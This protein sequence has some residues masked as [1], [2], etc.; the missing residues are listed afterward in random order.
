MNRPMSAAN[1]RTDQKGFTLIELLIV[2]AIIGILAAVAIPGYL[3]IQ[4]RGRKAVIVRAANA[5]EADLQGW[6]NSSNQIGPQAALIQCDTNWD[7]GVDVTGATD[8]PN[9]AM[10][11]IVASAYVSARSQ[12]AGMAVGAPELSP[13]SSGLSLWS[14]GGNVLGASSSGQIVVAQSI[15]TVSITAADLNGNIVHSKIITSD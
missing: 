10:T 9:S 12:A 4:E 8:L 6:L 5:A 11:G 2:V 13:W 3:G 1:S 7:G 14:D 15:N